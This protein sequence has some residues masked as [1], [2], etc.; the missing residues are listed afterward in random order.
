M[1]Y[2]FERIGRAFSFIWAAITM[3]FR[4]KDLILPSM[5]SIVANGL[6]AAAIIITLSATGSLWLIG[7]DS[8]DVEG[9]KSAGRVL[10]DGPQAAIDD[11]IEEE[12]AATAEAEA[13]GLT[14]EEYAAER[15]AE[16][17][18]AIDAEKTASEES[19][20]RIYARAAFGAA[21]IFGAFVITY[22]FSA[23]TVSLVYDHLSGKDARIGEAFAVAMARI[24]QLVMLAIASTVV[25]LISQAARGDDDEGVGAIIA[26]LIEQLWT[27]ASFLILPAMVI[28]R[29]S[30][31]GGLKRA[32]KIAAKNLLIVAVGEVAVGL[33]GNIIIFFGGVGGFFVGF[34]TY[35]V[36]PQPFY[37]PVGAGALV[38]FI[39]VAF[40]SYVKQ[41]YYTCLYLNAAESAEAGRRVAVKGPLAAALG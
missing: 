18:A 1:G 33:V 6:Y 37:V 10:R 31:W 7:W 39:A 12:K 19:K 20:S 8:G 16:R 17:Q 28:D 34:F 21:T 5:L 38:I 32:R 3:A 23:M 9:L 2:F 25:A 30:L 13:R 27:I 22:I 14:M 29:M 4:D 11:V 15:A 35:R 26:S 40:V 41:A 24:P 36:I